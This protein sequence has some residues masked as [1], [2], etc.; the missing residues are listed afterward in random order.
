MAFRRRF[1]ASFYQRNGF[2]NLLMGP[3]VVGDLCL[4]LPLVASLNCIHALKYFQKYA[5]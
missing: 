5:N 2:I 1:W 4:F 3:N